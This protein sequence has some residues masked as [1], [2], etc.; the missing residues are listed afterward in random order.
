MMLCSS[1]VMF[2]YP[3]SVQVAFFL[4]FEIP[5]VSSRQ[6]RGNPF[7]RHPEALALRLDAKTTAVI[8]RLGDSLKQYHLRYFEW[9]I[10]KNRG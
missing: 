4:L 2:C 8:V 10:K 3:Q 9:S 1:A 6:E 7:S 5:G